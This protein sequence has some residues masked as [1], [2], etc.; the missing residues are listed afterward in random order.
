MK[1]VLVTGA[2]GTIGLEVIKYLL[3]EGK[4]EIAVLDLKN[5]RT[6]QKLKKYKKRVNIIYGEINDR[7]LIEALVKDFDVIIHLAGALPPLAD[8]KKD[9]ALE[10]DYKGCENIVRAINYY[11]PKCHLFYASSM[12][13]YKDKSNVNTKTI[14]KLDNNDYYLI[15][16][17]EC[18]ALIKNKLKNY[19][20]YRFP[21]VLGKMHESL[22]LNGEKEEEIYYI[23]SKDAAY[24]LVKGL[25]Y[26]NELNKKVF[27]VTSYGKV[28]YQELLT[29]IL[30]NYGLSFKYIFNRLF[31]DKINTCSNCLDVDELDELIHYRVDSLEDYYS[32]LAYAGKKRPISRF[33]GRLI[34]KEKK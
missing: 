8:Y 1:K 13:L 26:L 17:K 20:I 28:K 34:A 3:S 10:I 25:D 32:R 31:I 5:S 23:T 7:I 29:K 6:I 33:L 24:S 21:L 16:K 19:S 18:E 2:A 30:R 14:I 9:L 22:L 4:Y 15:A 11:N 12:N 27:D